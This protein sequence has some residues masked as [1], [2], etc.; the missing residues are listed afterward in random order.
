MAPS[1][2]ESGFP[3]LHYDVLKAMQRYAARAIAVTGVPFLSLLLGTIFGPVPPIAT[4]FCAAVF[5]MFGL[6]G[7]LGSLYDT[8]HYIR[9][10]PYFQRTLGEIDTFLA[11]RSIARYL[12]QLDAI[13][14]E[15]NVQQLST[16][17]FADDLAGE[18]LHWHDPTLALQSIAAIQNALDCTYV[19]NSIRKAILD[20]LKKWQYA[21]ERAASEGV[22]FCLLLRHGNSTSGH[23]WDIRKGSA[24]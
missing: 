21:L 8:Y 10:I 3:Q 2:D 19:P 15:Q 5:L 12:A 6:V 24:F 22:Q 9:I 7:G 1:W 16:F 23:E 18:E 17:G 14:V 13:A 20:D 11:G 4:A